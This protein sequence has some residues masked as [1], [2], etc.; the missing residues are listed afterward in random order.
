MKLPRN[1]GIAPL[2]TSLDEAIEVGSQAIKDHP[3]FSV[4]ETFKDQDRLALPERAH[5]DIK[6]PPLL[7]YAGFASTLSQIK[8]DT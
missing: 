2:A 5:G 3:G 4:R 8:G 1:Q 7:P 6:K